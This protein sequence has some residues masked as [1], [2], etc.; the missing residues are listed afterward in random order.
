[1]KCRSLVPIPATLGLLLVAAPARA[2]VLTPI[3]TGLAILLPPIAAIEWIV[4]WL[5]AKAL[6]VPARLWKALLVAIVANVVSSAAGFL[7]G[8]GIGHGGRFQR[9]AGTLVWAYGLSVVIEWLVYLCFFRASADPSSAARGSTA[10]RW[11]FRACLFGLSVVVNLST[12][13]PLAFM[14]LTD[15]DASAPSG[16][17]GDVRTVLSCE[18]H[19]QE[20]A[21]GLYGDPA[22]LVTPSD[23]IRG[24]Q[25]PPMIDPRVV[26]DGRAKR[27]YHREFHCV[28][29]RNVTPKPTGNLCEHYAFTVWPWNPRQYFSAFCGDDTGVI[30]VRQDGR[31]PKVING[32]CDPSEE[33]V[34]P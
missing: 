4:L 15:P 13:V 32:N 2:D 20:V 18:S 28:P 30:R 34:R 25:G 1:M 6:K 17:L 31:A 26:V 10:R 14:V 16:A 9:N 8:M 7:P 23:C 19:F 29:A 12:Y 21:G 24:Y 33:F 22:C 11:K 3:G 5:V 27:S